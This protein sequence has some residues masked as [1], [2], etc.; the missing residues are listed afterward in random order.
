MLVTPGELPSQRLEVAAE[1][2]FHLYSVIIW[3]RGREGKVHSLN[4][5]KAVNGHHPYQKVICTQSHYGN[6]AL[7]MGVTKIP[8][9]FP[10]GFSIT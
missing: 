2:L 7:Q 4:A 10:N 8:W 1:H 5:N 6:F 9:H 3:L